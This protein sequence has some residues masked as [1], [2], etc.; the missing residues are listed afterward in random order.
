MGHCCTVAYLGF[1]NGEFYVCMSTDAFTRRS[2][3][4]SPIF[5]HG[6]D[7]FFL[8]KI[9][10]YIDTRAAEH[11]GCNCMRHANWLMVAAYSGI[12]CICHIHHHNYYYTCA[13]VVYSGYYFGLWTRRSLVR[14]P[15]GCRYSMRL[16]RLHMA[17]PSLFS[18]G[19]GHWVPVLSNIKTATACNS[20][21][22]LQLWT[23]FAGD[24]CG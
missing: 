4:R 21:K 10:A 15:S 17:H 20:N 12:I 6:H 5:P 18:F 2:K 9:V 13:S 22:Q 8:A 19:V 1:H 11:K 14:V 3:P 16:D 23:V 24:D 7:Y